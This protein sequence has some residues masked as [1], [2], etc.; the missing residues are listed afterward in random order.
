MTAFIQWLFD[1][2]ELDPKKEVIRS[3]WHHQRRFNLVV[4]EIKE[5][6]NA[7]SK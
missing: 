7:E 2:R 4:Q 1:Y 5:L 6:V 3:I